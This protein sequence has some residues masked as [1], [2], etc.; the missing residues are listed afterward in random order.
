MYIGGVPNIQE[1]IVIQ[2]N[3][4]GCIENIFLNSSNVI[5]D[6]KYAFEIGESLRYEKVGIGLNC[7][8]S[9]ISNKKVFRLENIVKREYM[10][11]F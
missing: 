6:M 4:S 3:Y 7:P 8:V 9:K 1:G 5:R 2:Q 10:F 11:F